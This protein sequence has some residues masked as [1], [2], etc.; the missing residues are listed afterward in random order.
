VRVEGEP[1][2]RKTWVEGL[3]DVLARSYEEFRLPSEL[4]VS[5][6]RAGRAIDVVPWRGGGD[7]GSSAGGVG[8]TRQAKLAS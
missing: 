6:G 4:N 1:G 8:K 3:E 7:G 2:S 5:W